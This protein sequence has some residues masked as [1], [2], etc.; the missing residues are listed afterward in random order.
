MATVKYTVVQHSGF[1]YTGK[2]AF[3]QGLEV[4]SCGRQAERDKVL[5]GGGMLFDE[6]AEADLFCDVAMYPEDHDGSLHPEARGG[7][8]REVVDGLRI[9]MPTDEDKARYF[10][11]KAKR[12]KE[13]T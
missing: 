13:V 3:K 11:E 12:E 5:R 10:A 9:Y 1:G 7:F 2:V 6:W 8:T 4:R